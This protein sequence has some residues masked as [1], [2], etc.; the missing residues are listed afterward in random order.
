M[1]TMGAR[2]SSEVRRVPGV[3]VTAPRHDGI[4]GAAAVVAPRACGELI[5]L[6]YDAIGAPQL[7]LSFVQRFAKL[8]DTE[9]A[10][11]LVGDDAQPARY[12]LASTNHARAAEYVATFHKVDP[13]RDPALAE[14]LTPGAHLSHNLIDDRKLR[15]SAFYQDFWRRWDRLFWACG[16]HFSLPTGVRVT[17]AAMRG[18]AYGCFEQGDCELVNVLL[19]HVL[20]AA[21]IGTRIDDLQRRCVLQAHVIDELLD[22]VIVIDARD[23]IVEMNARARALLNS[24]ANESCFSGRLLKLANANERERLGDAIA[25]VRSTA[26]GS[27]HLLSLRRAPPEPPLNALLTGAVNDAGYVHIFLRDSRWRTAPSMSALMSQL[28]LTYAQANV[29]VH[30]LR[31]QAPDEIAAE[32]GVHV[33]TVRAQIKVAMQKVG[34]HRTTELVRQLSIALPAASEL[35]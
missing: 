23:H 14:R 22:A 2:R 16:G 28:H 29:C 27:A 20:R 13:F 1:P 19:P 33:N 9:H 12:L 7:W 30:L 11:L 31:D 25:T 21:T 32:L 8:L 3:G 26:S 10:T 34:V 6:A 24:G 4:R 18:K 15:D 35:S 5:E 17:L